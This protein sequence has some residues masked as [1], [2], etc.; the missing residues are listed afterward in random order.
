MTSETL[1]L[2]CLLPHHVLPNHGPTFEAMFFSLHFAVF[3]SAWRLKAEQAS[4]RAV[5]Q[6]SPRSGCARGIAVAL[7]AVD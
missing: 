2:K 3:E 7:T 4:F 5:G 6:A 1:I